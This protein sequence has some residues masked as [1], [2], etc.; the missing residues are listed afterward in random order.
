[1][2]INQQW[3]QFPASYRET[4]VRTVAHWIGDGESGS[5]IGIT[6]V[7]R[8][9]FLEFLSYRLD[10]LQPYLP[11][12]LQQV[13][14]IPVDLNNLPDDQLS[15]FYRIL[16]RSFY[17]QQE[18]FK[19]S[20]QQTIYELY[21]KVEATQDP[22]LSQSALR[23][24]LTLFREQEMRIVL[25]MNRFDS[26]CETAT[27]QMTATL[28]GLRDSFKGTLSYIMGMEREIVYL[29]EVESI[30]PLQGILDTHVCWVGPLTEADA[31]HM[32]QRQ[33]QY[34]NEPIPETAMSQLWQLSGGYPSLLRVLCDWWM[35]ES[36]NVPVSLW[37]KTVLAKR[38][39]Q[40][41][42]RDIWQRLTD[43]EQFVLAELLIGSGKQ[44]GKRGKQ[45]MELAQL[46]VLA[47]LTR[48]GVCQEEEG[49][50]QVVG[51]LVCLYVEQVAGESR[52]RVHL[53][54][55][56]GEIYQGRTRLDGL[57]PLHHALLKF[58]VTR[59]HERHTH[60]D[61]IEAIWPEEVHKEGVSTEALYQVIRGIRK[62]IEA[63]TSKPRYLINW[64]GAFE[65]GYQFYPEGRP[66]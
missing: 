6:G 16:L 1:M 64:R 13:I 60:D 11:P 65:G 49:E 51:E 35:N 59:P 39:C 18:R 50:W 24:L 30:K 15:T 4:E 21:R 19:P 42:L 66:R 29:S 61:L 10:A 48:K 44:G 7:G 55:Q 47:G 56:T 38:N 62:A 27:P 5:V 14:L 23:E 33:T 31:R 2:G 37:G 54:A 63:D 22:F 40:H 3:F 57:Q 45:R 58:F 34:L 36:Q 53:E 52:G 9:T 41:R 17:E 20:L 43:E 28:R 46:A 32:I 12:R 26:F 8:T 25:V